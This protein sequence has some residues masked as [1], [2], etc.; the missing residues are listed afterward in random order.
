MP[1]TFARASVYRYFFRQRDWEWIDKG[2][3]G[4]DDLT[5]AK[6]YYYSYYYSETK[7]TNT[8][9]YWHYVDGEPTPW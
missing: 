6:R 7:P 4:N 5:N 8:G 1:C 2:V 9:K 3:F